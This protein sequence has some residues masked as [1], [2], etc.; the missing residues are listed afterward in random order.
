MIGTGSHA[1]PS[2]GLPP[3]LFLVHRLLHE[4]PI[5]LVVRILIIS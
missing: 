1:T 5:V 3:H 2:Y 4:T